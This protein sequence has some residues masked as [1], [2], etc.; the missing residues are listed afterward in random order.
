MASGWGSEG[1]VSN[2]PAT[3]DPRL[4]KIPKQRFPARTKKHLS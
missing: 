4:A 3:F 2:P 1:Q